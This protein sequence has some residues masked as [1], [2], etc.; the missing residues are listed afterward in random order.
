[1]NSRAAVGIS[2]VLMLVIFFISPE[3]AH[4][5]EAA[6]Q[7]ELI[8]EEQVAEE[9]KKTLEEGIDA[10]LDEL[11]L[12]EL[13]GIY[14]E[15]E[16]LGGSLR[17]AIVK[18][19]NE[20]LKDITAEQAFRVILEEVIDCLKSKMGEAVQIVIM[21][22]AMSLLKQL[23]SGLRGMEVSGAAFTAGYALI[24]TL[25][26]NILIGVV[27][28]ARA[29]IN[30]LTGVTEAITPLL[31][32]MLTGLGATSGANV[33]SPIMSALT[34]TVFTL[35]DKVVF[36]AILVMTVLAMISGFSKEIDLSGFVELAE[37]GTKWILGLTAIVFIGLITIKGIGGS[38]ID[39]IYFRTAKYTVEK[40]VPVVGS[41]FSD[42]FDTLMACGVIVQNTVG[43]VGMIM[44]A[45]K[46]IAPILSIAVDIL[47]LKAA[48]AIAA[49]LANRG[50][51]DMLSS[52]S[53]M[54]ELANVTLLVC[55][56]M[57]FISI[58]L[59]IGSAGVS[60]MMRE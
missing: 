48:A 43:T 12:T 37:K 8:D 11:D 59:L 53:K 25:T 33:M 57:A 39:G 58:A 18:I 6:A 44:I 13:E 42:T 26:A 1:M 15:D 36:P 27:T 10:T 34:G 56:M 52:A 20:G 5:A 9:T 23:S 51:R 45:A 32:A 4:A 22:L 16:L 24:C 31:T 60:F 28:D 46:L 19:S 29:G 50:S 55:S 21:I 38:A 35:I 54:A 7:E 41:M 2:V 17:E 49:P 3:C 14:E 47:L 30:S 40:M